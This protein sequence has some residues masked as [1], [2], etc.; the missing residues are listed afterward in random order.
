MEKTVLMKFD[1]ETKGTVRF[2]EVGD[3]PKGMGTLYIRKEVL[4]TPYPK[5]VSVNLMFK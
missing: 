4:D 3:E 5:E 1:K 2:K